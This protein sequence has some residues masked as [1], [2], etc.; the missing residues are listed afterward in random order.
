[1]NKALFLDRDGIINVDRGYVHRWED[2]EFIPEIFPLMELAIAK[3]YK[4]I[5]LTNQS[6]IDRGMYTDNDVTILHAKMQDFFKTKGIE[7]THWYY[8][9]KLDSYDRKPSPGMLLCAQKDYN[10][11]L[12]HSFM[13]GDKPSDFFLTDG[14]FTV[15]RT[16]LI[17]GNY[18]ISGLN[19]SRVKILN[20]H[21]ELLAEMKNYL[22]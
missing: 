18:E 3:N 5:V 14:S 19:D 13:V 9:A 8:C 4:I 20:N 2:V 22:V 10:I 16:F 11:D 1:M 12:E 21:S 6:G 17:K 7:I 15:P